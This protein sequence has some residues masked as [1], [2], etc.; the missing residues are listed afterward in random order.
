VPAWRAAALAFALL[1]TVAAVA[2]TTTVFNEVMYHPAT[3]AGTE[4]W[5]EL[6]NI[7]SVDMD[8]S[9][10]RLSGGVDFTFPE[11]TKITAG[12]YVIVAA[13]PAAV[14]GAIG[15]WDGRLAN[16]GEEIRLLSASGRIMDTL[17][18]GVGGRWPVG[19][20]GSGATLAR[21]RAGAA[22]PG[23]DAWTASREIGGTPGTPNFPDGPLPDGVRL[24]EI[25]GA[26]DG[27][28]RVELVN[29][30]PHPAPL[31][32]LR[33][34][35]FTPPAGTLAPGAF[36]VY[37]ETQLGF[38]LGDGVR[39]FLLGADGTELLDATTVRTTGRARHAGRM[40]VPAAPSFGA[41][42]SFQLS[43]DVVINEIMYRSPPFASREGT[44]AVVE[45]QEILPLQAVWRY[46]ADNVDLGPGWAATSHPVG[47]GWSQGPG[48]LGFETTPAAL[49]DQ[50]RTPFPSSNAITY[51]FETEFTLTAAQLAGLSTLRFE[52]VI[53]DGA[54]FYL[55]GQEVRD[56]R[57][58]LPD[59][60]IS[61]STLA[62]AG[63]ANA[64][65]S[66]PRDVPV[67]SLN[68]VAGV[69][70]LSVE[71]HQQIATGNDM[72]CG[73]RLS[74]ATIVTPESPASPVTTNP[75]EW[76]ELH[77]KG[78][79]PVDLGGWS[80]ADAVSFT[81]PPGTSIAPGG[82]LV[83]AND[84]AA[85]KANWPERASLILG[86]FSGS[87]SNNGER[88]ELRDATGNPADEAVY[89]PSPRSDGGG[90]S[91]ELADPR[92]DN[93]RPAAWA[94]S[95]E[96]GKSEWQTFSW[97]A[98][99]TQRFGPTTWNELRLG[100]LDAGECLIDDL[101]VRRDPD[102]AA[103]EL[104]RNGSFETLP[105]GAHWRFLGNHAGSRVIEDAA[106][107]G[108]HLLRFAATGPTETN[109][110]HAETT[111]VNNAALTSGVHEISFRARWLSGT[112]QLNVRAYYQKLAKTVELPIPARLGTP[113]APNSRAIANAGPVLGELRHAPAIPAANSPVTVSLAA[114]DPDGLAGA[115][116]LYRLNGT[117][118]FTT[119]PMALANGRWSATIP[120]QSAG[121]IVH[122]YA[123]V[124]DSAGAS[125]FLPAR[126]PDSR[127]LVQWQDSQSTT[128]AAHQIRL[129]MLAADRTFLLETFNRLSNDRV[130]GTLIYRG[131]EVFHDV[132]VRLQGT[133]A[134]RVRDGDAYI[135]YDIGFPPDHLFRGLH[136]SIG[137]DR[138]ARSPVVRRQDEIYVRHTFNKAGLLCTQ[139]DLCYF[140]AP[141][142]TH[143][144][145]AILQ[146]ASYGGLWTDS[147]FE[148]T[149]GTVYNW[150]ITYD[151]TTTSVAGNPESLKPPVP[152]GHITTDLANLGTDKEQY[153]GPFD[154]RAG[155]RRDDYSGL[156]RLAQTMPLPA[157]QLA[158]EAPNLLDLD[159]VFRTTALVN[160]WGIGD[161]YYTGGLPHNIRLFVP[162]S[163][164]NISFLPWD[165]DFV[166]SG[167]SNS[168]ILPSGNHLGRLITSTPAHRRLYLGHVRHLCETVFTTTYLNPWLTHFGSVVGQSFNGTSSYITARRTYAQSQYPAQTPFAITTNGGADVTTEAREI[169][170][171][172]TGWI[173]LKEIRRAGV[174]LD[175][176]WTDLTHWRATVPIESGLNP[177]VL[178]AI[179]FAGTPLASR[180]LNVT[181]TAPPEPRPV[182]FL[183]VTEL[184][185][186]PA[187]PATPA[188]LAASTTDSDF[189]FIELGN[190]GTAPLRLDGVRFTQG[191]DF[192]V[193][194]NT[195]LAAGRFAVVVR[196]PAA[197]A[198]RYGTD[199]QV[200]GAFA[201]S[202]LVNSGETLTLVDATGAVIQSF[203]YADGWFPSS[204]G[205]G[206]SLVARDEL[207]A[208]PDLGAAA[209]WSL[210]RQRHGNP[211]ASNG[212]AY[213]HEFTGWQAQHFTAEQLA[214][215]AVSGPDADPAGT[216]VIN[217]LR[218]A[219]GQPPLSHSLPPTP[220]A[221]TAPDGLHLVFRRLQHTLDLAWI[222]ESST[223]LGAWSP[224]ATAPSVVES[225]PDSTESI[226]WTLP[227]PN[228][229]TF[230]RIRVTPQ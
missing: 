177:I 212:P 198:A 21:R 7:M 68:L 29:E 73:V 180:S 208:T 49:P 12:G 192:V 83:I 197:F 96:S 88:I 4:E 216:G 67:A 215:P 91:L 165:M 55:N 179:G 154:I 221:T 30:G 3:V 9:G 135:G 82:F 77:N 205:P 69:N 108:N 187:N 112:N 146:L 191:I 222:L 218:Y 46:R 152:F 124:T 140:F 40:L 228:Q 33:L 38:R 185:Y 122:F 138:S 106:S 2:D 63:I 75:E 121:A 19:P 39:L 61:H 81:L 41:A 11:G 118:G 100:M 137:I 97:R 104:L 209:S 57:F 134:G 114:T 50:L 150:D 155:K 220:T 101:R 207:A 14:P 90:S 166:M 51:Y 72:V 95:D 62:T 56:L 203:T 224:V 107:P 211:G 28:F 195:T 143:T 105:A 103:V 190:I 223:S 87:L 204:D 174:R 127:A 133:A 163:G 161:S 145:T 173:D 59:T 130:P 160:L 64:V 27:V 225:H 78:A 210:S 48:L 119:L 128:V 131:T 76:I 141:N 22:D 206:W 188:E 169:V 58:N 181:S 116:L 230:F 6:A 226:R 45:T 171:E 144:G 17:D 189:E 217:L 199:I 202:S 182:D 157:A 113:G 162:D 1:P 15:P 126:G 139:D 99:G 183:R 20:D 70:R 85:L 120:G 147:Q 74:A 136:E 167:A 89:L 5:I 98:P 43:S 44:P 194:N 66:T 227:L 18:Y 153:R 196:H 13:M 214:N 31:A 148:D 52:H 10:W 172:G 115:T 193:P 111:F 175:L 132:G 142:T 92:S 149:P 93:S 94:D 34:G 16:N 71:V 80:L 25:S 117:S 158:V 159:Q 129:I 32:S 110:N 37:D 178:D 156:M 229:P 47:D 125:S 26:S 84:S 8:L 36:I 24:S 186:H 65:L 86:D 213:S 60:A 53:D 168:A 170:L 164:Q 184:H 176:T 102:G 42:N 219:T 123:T 54:A 151:P 201:P 23:P 109:H 200:L 35:S 79:A